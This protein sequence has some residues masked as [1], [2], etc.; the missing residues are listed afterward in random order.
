MV[1]RKLSPDELGTWTLIT[2]IVS[3]VLI[4]D[5][6]ISYWSTRQTARG[7]DVGK[8]ALFTGGMFTIGGI[9]VYLLMAIFFS[10][11]LSIDLNVLILATVL[12]PLMFL[13]G[14]LSAIA[15]G[16]KPHI[17]QYGI[18]AFEATK[19]P[20]GLVLVV[21]FQL[22][23][24]GAILTIIV[25]NS[26]RILILIMMLK[27]KLWGKLR[28][29]VLKFWLKMSWLPMYGAIPGLIITFDVVLF[30]NFTHS[31]TGLAYWAAGLTVAM[32]VTQSGTL[33]QALY[34]KIIATG[35]KEF[36]EENIRKT[37]FFAIP[38]LALSLIFAK[39]LLHI[40][41]PLYADGILI[42]YF[43]SL[44]AF[45]AVLINIAYGVLRAYDKVDLDKNATF[46]EYMKSKLFLIPTLQYILSIIYITSLLLF[47]I[48][49]ST[50]INDIDIVMFWSFIFFIVYIPFTVYGIISIHK[51]HQIRLPYSS[52]TKFSLV[53]LGISLLL[54]II[55]D[56]FLTY[57]QSIWEFLPEI[58]PM[59]ILGGLLYFGISYFIDKSIK[60]LF[61]SIISEIRKS[62]N[63]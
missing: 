60:S 54:L 9:L 17:E 36:A 21:N 55:K 41:N 59:I 51:N 58:L 27:E 57:P 11:Y 49:R 12:V 38:F 31:L 16:Y 63:L 47:L 8:T 10:N 14:T 33:S 15:H 37:L 7:D 28:R 25:A 22:G 62:F 29:E 42:V 53:T 43:L 1:T 26:V 45:V 3:Y 4:V 20:I 23:V 56:N 50:A 30:S 46:K 52:I 5:P 48:F 24:F 34:P 44:K 2:T 39:P 19:I 61:N 35:K 6:I 32:L 40:I 18:M 13:H